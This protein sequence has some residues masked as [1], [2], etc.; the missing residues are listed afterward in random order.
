[1]WKI[2]FMVFE[3][4]RYFHIYTIVLKY[5]GL[6][7]GRKNFFFIS[8]PRPMKLK[9]YVYMLL[10][11]IPVKFCEVWVKTKVICYSATI[12]VKLPFFIQ[13]CNEI[14]PSKYSKSFKT[15][16][17]SYLGPYILVMPKYRG[18]S[19]A[20]KNFFFISCPTAMKL[21]TDV[22]VVLKMNANKF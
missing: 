6:S 7:K 22:S 9:V 8:C 17:H 19:K 18:L 12:G 1:M 15:C 3:S 16:W 14:S 10:Y 11:M 20:R 13:S 4:P 2:K 5:R 21:I